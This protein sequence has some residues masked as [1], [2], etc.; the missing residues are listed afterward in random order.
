MD[1]AALEI[2]ITEDQREWIDAQV[3]AGR[4]AS[5]S[6]YIRELIRRDQQAH[7]SLRFALIHGGREQPRC[8]RCG[9]PGTR[10]VARMIA[11]FAAV[12]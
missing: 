12:V 7:K 1:M 3:A 9:T 11:S 6:D 5:A 2:S 10:T 4:Y 8:Q